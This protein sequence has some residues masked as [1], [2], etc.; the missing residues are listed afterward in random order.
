MSII[1]R[2][3]RHL[4]TLAVICLSP[5]HLFQG[6]TPSAKQ[7]SLFI[8]LLVLS[9]PTAD[10]ADLSPGKLRSLGESALMER[11]Y[12]TAT[13]YYRQAIE[14]EPSNAV[15]WYKLF[16]C[17]KRQRLLA[18]ALDDI[19]NA[20]L[21]E[22]QSEKT[23]SGDT[24]KLMEYREQ[25]AKLLVGLGRCEEAIQEYKLLDVSETRVK[26]TEKAMGCA[27]YINMANASISRED[28]QSAT[29]EL[30]EA[31][32]FLSSPSDAP[33]LLF[34][35]A[36][37]QFHI[38]DYYGAISDTGKLLKAYPQHLEAY[39]LRG[40]SYW[41]LNEVEMA[42][43][44]FRE[45]LKLDPEHDGC[46]AGHRQMKKVTKKDKKGD[47]HFAKG[48]YKQ[49]IDAWWEAMN[50]DLSHLHFVRP[51]L[52]KVVKAHIKL[53]EY[54]KA[55][56]EANKHVE[57]EESVEG[58]HAL[59]EA[60]IAGE[61]FDEA[62]RTYQR[63]M[64]IAPDGEKRQCQQKVEEAQVALK[65]SK[66]KNY[67]KILGVQRN[68]D[69]KQIKKEYKKLA[70]QWHPDKNEDKEK[71][72]KMF[73]DISEAYE[74]L[75]DKEMRAKYDRGEPVFENQ[76][77]GGGGHHFHPNHFFHHGGGGGQ[78]FRHGGGQ[79]MHFNFG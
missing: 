24:K 72:E 23:K 79:R 22:M 41:R 42:G 68:A 34:L 14:L 39:A 70:L 7:I 28:W 69:L 1:Q 6:H 56:E 30:K 48:N 32:N 25:K 67:Y 78:H 47:E 54:D 66:E 20:V 17:H 15:N 33:D 52:L 74:V 31:L 10:A 3:L 12:A 8:S 13:S 9:T 2:I 36:R 76:G 29:N 59:G 21:V 61:K 38:Q 50:D 16:N 45:G 18:D 49:A 46:K 26:D 53:G 44:H 35:L 40:D 71:A 51:T 4:T 37:S 5:F 65:Q 57:N 60:L 64:E 73:Q 43:K 58:L 19:T 62:I 63:A 75:S 27:Q 77:H 11:D 55:V